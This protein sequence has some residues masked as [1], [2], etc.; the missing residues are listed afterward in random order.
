[1]DMDEP[2]VEFDFDN[3]TTCTI[4]YAEFLDAGD[5]EIHKAQMHIIGI[6]NCQFCA[7]KLMSVEDYALHIRDEH[8]LNMKICQICARVFLDET[9]CR[10]HEKKHL[11]NPNT[12]KYSCSQCELNF[13]S[14]KELE[15]H[16]FNTHKEE[17]YARGFWLQDF[18]PH[19]ASV[20]NMTLKCILVEGKRKFVCTKCRATSPNLKD[21]VQHLK[22]ANCRSLTCNTCS[23]VY[24]SKKSMWRHLTKHGECNCDMKNIV[25]KC[26]ICL[27][28]FPIHFWRYHQ[29][30]CKVIKCQ[31]CEI[32]F[33]N[34][35]DLAKHQTEKHPLV[36][37]V[38]VCKYCNRE[39]VG[40]VGLDKHIQR[41]HNIEL[42]KYKCVHCEMVFKH[43]QKL[44]A[45]FYTKHKEMEPY[46]CCICDKKFKI[47]KN[48]TIHIKLEHS[49]KGFVEFDE[50]FNVYFRERRFLTQAITTNDN[51]PITN[52]NTGNSKDTS[53]QKHSEETDNPKKNPDA[54]EKRLIEIEIDSQPSETK[55][56]LATETEAQT[57]N[58]TKEETKSKRKVKSS[59]VANTV[60]S[61]GSDSFDDQP[62]C[63][64][65]KN[66][67][68]HGRPKIR[69]RNVDVKNRFTCQHCNKI[70]NT[71]QNYHHHLNTVH[72]NESVK[73]V[74]CN[75]TFASKKKLTA[76]IAKEHS[77][78]QLTE[79]L[80]KV[81]ANRQ[82]NQISSTDANTLTNSQKF[83]RTI[84]K[85]DCTSVEEPAT[86]KSISKELSV[87]KFIESFT[88]ETNEIKKNIIIDSNVS[89]K[90]V[91]CQPKESFIKLTKF[92]PKEVESNILRANKL[93]MPVRFKPDNS[94]Q[95]SVT[96]KVVNAESRPLFIKPYHDNDY[97]NNNDSYDNDMIKYHQ[98]PEVAQEVMLEGS[99]E[100]PKSKV[101][102]IVIPNIPKEMSQVRIATLQPEAPY[103]KIIKISDVLKK[104]EEL[105]DEKETDIILPNGKKLVS[106][107]PLAHLLG[108][109]PIEKIMGQKNKYYKYQPKTPNFEQAVAR[110][111]TV[112]KPTPM[113]KRK[114]TKVE[115]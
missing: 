56:F 91:N 81:L 92:Q 24:K 114:I 26:N 86:L 21:Y 49:S 97:A 44:F 102:K 107:N 73:C 72:Q 3:D 22:N 18:S 40:K 105:K 60:Y 100:V 29:N 58:E 83:E 65:R 52:A 46:F 80:K 32:P 113:K 45:H 20:L 43:P 50:K 66:I 37:S 88:P 109:T 110:A 19:L 71:Y 75:R 61:S 36:V 68:K 17:D 28:V 4:C 16:E 70:C 96:V 30:S 115:P 93:S 23:C 99:E 38:Q 64:V 7:L 31:I 33:E 42:Y 103:Y 41:T 67:G 57:E 62:L 11:M 85:V 8:L 78:S 89:I 48:F 112:V 34:L 108:D 98:I 82:N 74:K 10:K 47:R 106:V 51:S 90:P 94:E 5:L 54:V 1:M 101:H 13:Y 39:F 55:D 104:P 2:E 25:K 77:F 53:E 12:A 84:K 87:Q 69:R 111:L 15:K 63:V 76:H 9:Y 35:E 95:N 59:R 6:L 27:K 14:T 79:T